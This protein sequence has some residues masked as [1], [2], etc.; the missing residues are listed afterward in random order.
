MPRLLLFS[1]LLVAQSFAWPQL[2]YSENYLPIPPLNCNSQSYLLFELT[3]SIYCVNEP[4]FQASKLANWRPLYSNFGSF[5]ICRI[6]FIVNFLNLCINPPRLPDSTLLTNYFLQNINLTSFLFPL[7]FY[8]PRIPEEEFNYF[9]TSAIFTLGLIPIHYLTRSLLIYLK[10]ASSTTLPQVYLF[11]VLGSL[12][13]LAIPLFKND[14][15]S[16]KNQSFAYKPFT[17]AL[18]GYIAGMII[19]YSINSKCQLT[20]QQSSVICTY[21]L[22][23]MITGAVFGHLL[24]GNTNRNTLSGILLGGWSGLLIGSSINQLIEKHFQASK[25][26]LFVELSLPATTAIPIIIASKR[27]SQMDNISVALVKFKVR[28]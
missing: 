25:K 14:N 16:F 12:T 1:M 11:G 28:F 21:S 8:D 5:P 26:P 10:E 6:P 18:G 7:Y 13:G 17:G 24:N 2:K 4:E 23:G 19:A 27:Y 22:T 15:Y 3:S 9:F 20:Y